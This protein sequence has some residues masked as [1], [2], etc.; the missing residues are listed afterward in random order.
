MNNG[1]HI[2][3]IGIVW[4]NFTS[5]LVCG[6][7]DNTCDTL[8]RCDDSQ[9]V[10]ASGRKIRSVV[11]AHPGFSLRKVCQDFSLGTGHKVLYF[12]RAWKSKIEL[13]DPSASFDILKRITQNHTV[14]DDRVSLLK[15]DKCYLV[16]LRN[17]AQNMK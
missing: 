13:V 11:I 12:R 14:S 3:H 2:I 6:V 7:A 16:S 4:K 1:N 5:D 8:D 10:S 15:V 17:V 9:H